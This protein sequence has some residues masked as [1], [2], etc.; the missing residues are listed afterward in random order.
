MIQQGAR[1]VGEVGN[2]KKTSPINPGPD[3]FDGQKTKTTSCT[4]LRT[5]VY[6]PS[7]LI[8]ELV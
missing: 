6:L 3:F 2:A 8:L 4:N 1:I 7:K 5:L